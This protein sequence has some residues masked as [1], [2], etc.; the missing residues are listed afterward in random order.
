MHGSNERSHRSIRKYGINVHSTESIVLLTGLQWRHTRQNTRSTARRATMPSL[1]T[2]YHAIKPP[3]THSHS[4]SEVF[5]WG[6]MDQRQCTVRIARGVG[7][8]PT[9]VLLTPTHDQNMYRDGGRGQL[10]TAHIQFTSQFWS[11]SNCQK[12]FNPQY[13][14]QFITCRKGLPEVNDCGT[15]KTQYE[16]FYRL[17][18]NDPTASWNAAS[19][20]IHALASPAMGHWGTC[21]PGPPAS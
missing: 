15:V 8:K 11:K 2:D 14:P 13:F 16:N 5:N 9:T 7:V 1:A 6:A 10:Y 3:R 21:P 19:F 18:I 4:K 20:R 17:T 12:K